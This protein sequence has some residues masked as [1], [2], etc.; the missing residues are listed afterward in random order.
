MVEGHRYVEFQHSHECSTISSSCITTMSYTG[1]LP[2]RFN[3]ASL[4]HY[5][6]LL[7]Y[8]Y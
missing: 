8:S 7:S 3:R 4:L 5:T 6:I 2:F 1:R